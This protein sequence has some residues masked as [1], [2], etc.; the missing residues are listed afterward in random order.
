[1]NANAL[2]RTSIHTNPGVLGMNFVKNLV[3]LSSWIADGQTM[4]HLVYLLGLCNRI[5]LLR[6]EDLFILGKHLLPD[7]L[8]GF[9]LV[10]RELKIGLHF[11]SNFENSIPGHL[12]IRHQ[13][14][15]PNN[16]YVGR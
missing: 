15:F 16:T 2:V 10:F 6:L 7:F 3:P 5:T 1:M 4:E 14:F 12:D 9:C 11:P 8:C 13:S